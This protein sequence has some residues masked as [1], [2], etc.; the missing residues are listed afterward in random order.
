MLQVSIK[1]EDI[2]NKTDTY[3]D[4]EDLDGFGIDDDFDDDGELDDLLED[5]DLPDFD[6]D[7]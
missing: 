5:D 4:E 7:I 3:D 1:T 6:D 2:F